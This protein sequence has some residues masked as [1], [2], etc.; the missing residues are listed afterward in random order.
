MLPNQIERIRRRLRAVFV[1]ER[2]ASIDRLETDLEAYFAG[3]L[4]SFET[5]LELCGTE[6]QCEVWGALREVPYGE[7][8]SYADIARVV[9]RPGAVRAVGTANGA[10]ALALV[11]PC[12]RVV[13][14]DG[15]LAGYGGGLWR[16][17]RLLEIE[18]GF[19]SAS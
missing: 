17:R 3:D 6:F 7:T 8:R 1:P 16:K 11:V 4:R 10:N 15:R 13:A 5:P 19:A 9:G 18:R 14:S 2:H 12:H